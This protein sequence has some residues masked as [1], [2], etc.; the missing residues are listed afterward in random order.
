MADIGIPPKDAEL[1]VGA[2]DM[3]VLNYGRDANSKKGDNGKIM[4][5]G[6]SK[7]YTGAVM[8]TALSALTMGADLVNVYTPPRDVAHDIRS[9]N[10]SI[11][12]IPMEGGFPG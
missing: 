4:V 2:G 3:L 7:Y 12:A 5:I 8:F 11:I 10:P 9:N 1:L 6:G